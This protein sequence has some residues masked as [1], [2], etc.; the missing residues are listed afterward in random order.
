MKEARIGLYQAFVS[1]EE[2]PE[3]PEPGKGSLDNPPVVLATQLS[4]ILI[5][6][7]RICAPCGDNRFDSP[8]LQAFP[9][10]IAVV[11]S[12]GN[13]SVGVSPGPPRMMASAHRDRFECFLEERGL[14][15]GRR[16]QVS[17][18]RSARAIDQ[19]HPLRTFASLCLP[20]FGAPFF[21]GA[22][23][24]SAK[25]SS[26]HR[27]SSVPSSSQCRS[28]CQQI[29]GLAYSRG[30]SLHGAPVQRI[31]RIPSKRLRSFV[32]GWPPLGLLVLVGSN[33]PTRSHCASVSL[34]HAIAHLLVTRHG[35]S[36][37]PTEGF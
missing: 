25:H 14:R 15:L 18:Q 16:A 19:K 3:P 32:G 30:N 27:A 11:A 20:D 21:A 37:Y 10:R 17:S 2:P 5:G 6:R 31:Q 22:K 33:T 1:H 23:L 13:Q 34:R 36:L 29:D 12:V 28:R 26:R 4:A 24:P 7:N 35:D 9:Q 8:S